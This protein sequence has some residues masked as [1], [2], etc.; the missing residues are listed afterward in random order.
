MPPTKIDIYLGMQ[1][2]VIPTFLAE[3]SPAHLRGSM[4][5]LYWLSIK[6][7]FK[8]TFIKIL[9]LSVESDILE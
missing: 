9:V 1:L 8:S 5:V 4:G 2:A 3:I 6:V 7:C